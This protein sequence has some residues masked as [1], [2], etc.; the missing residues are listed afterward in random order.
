VKLSTN[1]YRVGKKFKFSKMNPNDT[2]P[3]DNT[4]EGK[5]EAKALLEKQ[6]EKLAEQQELFYANGSRA[7]LVVFQAMDAGG[8]DGCIENVFTGMNPAGVRVA[9]FKTP[10][11]EELSHDFLWRIHKETPRKGMVGV[12]NRSHYEDVL[13][14]RVKNLVP[15][16]VWSKRYDLINAFEEGLTAAGT[17]VIK[18]YLHVDKDEQKKRLQARLDDPEKNWKFNPGDLPERENWEA[19]MKAFKKIFEECSSAESPWYVVPANNKWY[20]D[21]VVAQ[22]MLEALQNMK[23]KY[24]KA[25][26][27]PATIKI[28]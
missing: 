27:D 5:V 21:I 18:I 23:L 25:D 28:I 6:K 1:D 26:Y 17:K 3:F 14:V 4:D 13:I 15:K 12:F 8:K 9:S 7:L 11:A 22:I 19:Y 24:P 20:R 10:T 2:G 16:E